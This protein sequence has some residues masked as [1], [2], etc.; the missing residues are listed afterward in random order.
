[1][2]VFAGDADLEDVLDEVGTAAAVA[3][4]AAA[5]GDVVEVAGAEPS[6]RMD[7]A[8]A[9]SEAVTDDHVVDVKR[10]SW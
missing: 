2:G 9:H 5:R 10:A 8:V 3:P 7:A 1:M 6:L 4:G